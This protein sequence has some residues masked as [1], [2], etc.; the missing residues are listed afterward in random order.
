M[1]A[2]AIMAL[3]LAAAAA[4]DRWSEARA[5]FD[6]RRFADA[7]AMYE[8][9]A[10]TGID[11][12]AV[13]FNLGNAR[14]GAGDV[15]GAVAAYRR[16][17][18]LAPRDADIRGNLQTAIASRGG[19]LPAR[20]WAERMAETLSPA[21]AQWLLAAG[22]WALWIAWPLARW[23][24]T[25]A[26]GRAIRR[27]GLAAAV[28]V[29]AA[30]GVLWHWRSTEAEQVVAQAGHN[31]LFAPLDD[32][33]A[34]FTL[35]VGSIVRVVEIRGA[36]ARVRLDRREGWVRREILA[37]VPSPE[38]GLQRAEAVRIITP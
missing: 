9:A 17:W 30:G 10:R 15:G 25:T 19:A 6:A 11:D 3:G 7:A 37:G 16:A 32:A 35:P 4:S 34:Y 31:A 38:N 23:R 33:R 8:A 36:W 22:W 29:A 13:W 27:L 20:S 1:T 28:T 14:W 12:P 21:E 24:R 18:R 5:A 2:A 26:V